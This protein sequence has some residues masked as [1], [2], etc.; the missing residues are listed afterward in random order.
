MIVADISDRTD[1]QTVL[2]Y[3]YA[4]SHY[5]YNIQKSIN[6]LNFQKRLFE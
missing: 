4:I 6:E 1:I 2:T 3:T 5:M